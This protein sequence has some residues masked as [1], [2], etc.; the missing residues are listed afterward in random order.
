MSVSSSSSSSSSQPFFNNISLN[1]NETNGS[2]LSS[3]IDISYM[4][5]LIIFNSIVFCLFIIYLR[6]LLSSMSSSC[7]LPLIKKHG[8]KIGFTLTLIDISRGIDISG[9]FF[10]IKSCLS[11]LMPLI[12]VKI[13]FDIRKTKKRMNVEVFVKQKLYV[14]TEKLSESYMG[15]ECLRWKRIIVEIVHIKQFQSK[16]K[17]LSWKWRWEIDVQNWTTKHFIRS[18]RVLKMTWKSSKIRKH[19]RKKKNELKFYSLK[20]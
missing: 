13:L 18:K 1:L 20:S 19:K 3:S 17:K 8:I 14:Y 10:N 15:N 11:T 16:R 7:T 5:E 12:F 6:L 2:I 9:N 4:Y